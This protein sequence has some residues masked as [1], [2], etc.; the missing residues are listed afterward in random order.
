ME[1]KLRNKITFI[2]ISLAIFLRLFYLSQ[3]SFWCDEFLAISLSRIPSFYD[4][5]Y[6]IIKYDAHPPLFYSIIRVVFQFTQSEF[7]LRFLP[8]LFGAGAVIIFYRLLME[9]NIKNYLL[10]L[11][12]FAFSPPAVL[13][14]QIVKSYSTLTFFSLLSLLMLIRYK[15]TEK[16]IYTIFWIISSIFMLYLHNYGVLII[17]GQIIVLWLYR[18]VVPLKKFSIPFL[19]IFLLYL[20]YFAGPLFSQIRF[21]KTAPH[22]VVNPFF[23]LGYT[24][25]YFIFGETLSPLNFKFVIPGLLLFLVF[26]I[27]GICV[28]KNFFQNFSVIVL[29]L[30][31]IVIFSVKATIPQNLIHLQP[32]FFILVASGVESIKKEKVKIIFSFLLV[33]NLIPSLWYYYQEDSLQYHDVSK[34]IPYKEIIDTIKKEEKRG[35]VVIINEDRE[36]RFVEFFKPYSP[37]DWYYKGKLPII[38]ITTDLELKK[39]YNK[40]TGFWLILRYFSPEYQW[41]EDIK[42]FFIQS[43]SAKI[44]EWKLIKNYSFLNVLRGKGKKEYYLIEVYHF[45]K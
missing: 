37:W 28:K 27:R 16:V 30:G 38:E 8:F 21:V 33:L 20:P 13:W 19:V 24:F 26:F 7:G 36:T 44:K 32:F 42:N 4:M 1:L 3:K 22:S 23:R 40:Y 9:L 5:V 10:P 15:K 25:F 31:I 41:N 43:K 6:R 39:L 17:A 18:K 29:A 45:V 14:S 11:S 12:L 34:L 35:E 2:I